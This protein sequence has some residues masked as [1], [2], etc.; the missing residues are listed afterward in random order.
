MKTLIISGLVMLA[1]VSYLPVGFSD[2][3]ID[4]DLMKPY[5]L[6]TLTA[7]S[8]NGDVYFEQKVHNAVVNLGEN[9]M[10]REIFNVSGETDQLNAAGIDAICVTARSS[11]AEVETETAAT[12]NAD[13]GMTV[14]ANCMY[15]EATVT[16]A[17]AATDTNDAVVTVTFVANTNMDTGGT[18]TGIAIGGISGTGTQNGLT[19]DN[20]S[21]LATINIGDVTPGTNG[22]T[23]AVTYTMQVS[24][25]QSLCIRF[26]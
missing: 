6:L 5:G 18:V 20:F 26:I 8:A 15:D 21:L 9:Y 23:L 11:F 24:Y 19:E 22:D 3:Q 13:D 4:S 10:L 2:G 25:L 7:A 1:I 14:T 12:F 16:T 17:N